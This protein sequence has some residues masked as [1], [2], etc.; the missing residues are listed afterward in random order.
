MNRPVIL[1][2]GTPQILLPYDNANRSF[3]SCR[4]YRGPLASWTAW[5]APKTM[6]PAD[7]AQPSAWARRRCARSTASRRAMLDQGRARRCSCRARDTAIADVSST[8]ADNATMV[9]AAR[10]AAAD[11]SRRCAPASTTAS[12]RSRKRYHVSASQVAQWNDVGTGAKFAPGQTVVVYVAGKGRSGAAPT[13]TRAATTEHGT[14]V[15]HSTHREGGTATAP[16]ARRAHVSVPRQE[17]ARQRAA[18]AA[19]RALSADRRTR[20]RWSRDRRTRARCRPARRA[21]AGS[22]V[23]PRG[24]SASAITCAVASPSAVKLVARITSST[25][26]SPA[27]SSSSRAPMSRRPDAVERA[28]PAHQHEVEAAVAAGALERRLVGRRLDHAQLARVARGSRQMLQTSASVKVWQRSQWRIACDRVL[29]RAA[30][31]RAPSRSCC[32]RWKA[33]R[34]ADLTPT[35]GRRAQR[36]DRA[37]SSE[38]VSGAPTRECTLRTAASCRAA[39]ACRR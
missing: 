8:V 13:R 20:A 22:R 21:R 6:K 11:A 15:A 16:A 7:A 28:E 25:A 5:V 19:A 30:M 34:C 33:M 26:P 37:P 31:R 4:C 36:L 38:P 10:C 32:S 12:T 18:R 29:K 3:A 17:L 35:P 14:R 23:M 27:R 2:A 1:A 9:L 39:A 24:L